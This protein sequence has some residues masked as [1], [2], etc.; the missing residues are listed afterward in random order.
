MYKQLPKKGNKEIFPT[1]LVVVV[2]VGT[3]LDGFQEIVG[4]DGLLYMVCFLVLSV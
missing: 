4:T 1:L 3:G 2:E